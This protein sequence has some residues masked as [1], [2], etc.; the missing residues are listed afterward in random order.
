MSNFHV[1]IATERRK[2][3]EEKYALRK[4]EAEQNP[5]NVSWIVYVHDSELQLSEDGGE[6]EMVAV[7]KAEIFATDG[8]ANAYQSKQTAPTEVVK[9]VLVPPDPFPMKQI[10]TSVHGQLHSMGERIDDLVNGNILYAS[11]WDGISPWLEVLKGSIA[12]LKMAYA[13]WPMV[14]RAT[15]EKENP[16]KVAG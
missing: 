13:G 10:A 7:I 3:Y 8:E 1:R 11:E 14:D 2:S 15:W 6:P 12:D 9:N 5:E 4:A 16:P